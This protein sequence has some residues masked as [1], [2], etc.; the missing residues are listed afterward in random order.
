[1]AGCSAAARRALTNPGALRMLALWLVSEPLRG[2][3]L[4]RLCKVL[5]EKERSCMPLGARATLTTIH[6]TRC[7]PLEIL[8]LFGPNGNGR[9]TMTMLTWSH[10]R[11]SEQQYY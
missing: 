2:L 9:A 5:Q 1:M 10:E 7:Q 8:A 6:S 3:A 11:V 4:G